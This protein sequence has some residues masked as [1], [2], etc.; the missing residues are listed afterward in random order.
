MDIP[1]TEE[2]VWVRKAVTKN[3]NFYFEI[4]VYNIERMFY[5]RIMYPIPFVIT[6]DVDECA[7]NGH[8]CDPFANCTNTDGNF[9]CTCLPGYKGNGTHCKG[10]LYGLF[11]L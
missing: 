7:I 11:L 9:N 8:N 3:T 4:S 2:S 10:E 1:E 5:S 6:I